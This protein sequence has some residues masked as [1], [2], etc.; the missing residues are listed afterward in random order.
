MAVD[1]GEL[2]ESRQKWGR[3]ALLAGAVSAATLFAQTLLFLID[4]VGILPGGPPFR[5]T[6]AGRDE[7]LAAF[8]V[9]V[10]ER[11]HDVAWNIALRDVAGPIAAIARSCSPA[12]SSA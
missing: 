12:P 7:D 6:G 2:R 10:A 3:V 1:E 8:F 5:E 11:Q 9:G 4:A